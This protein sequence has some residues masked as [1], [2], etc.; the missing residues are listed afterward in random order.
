MAFIWIVGGTYHC[1]R[2][3]S[4]VDVN[5]LTDNA[6]L[7]DPVDE[8]DFLTTKAGCLGFGS[9]AVSLPSM[10]TTF[11]IVG[12]SSGSSCTHNSPTFI[13]LKNSSALHVSLSATSIKSNALFSLHHDSRLRIIHRDLK[14]SNVLL[15]EEMNPKISDFGLARIFGGKQTEATTARVVGT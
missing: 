14:T 5:S 11:V 3:I 9:V 4:N 2:P 7:E 15:D 10:Y 12:R 13:H 6:L 1:Q 8:I